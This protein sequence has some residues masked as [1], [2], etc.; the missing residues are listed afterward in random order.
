LVEVDATYYALL[1]PELAERWVSTTPADFCFDVKAHPIVTGHPVDIAR[2]PADLKRALE[3]AGHSR[4]VYPDRMPPEIAGEIEQRFRALV[5]P[6]RAAGKLGCVMVQFPPWFKATR[7]N[8]Q[9]IERLGERW[10]GVPI[11]IEFRD[12]SWLLPERRERVLDLLRAHSFSY[13][14]VDEP[15]VATGGVPPLV[16]VTNPE[17]SLVRFHGHNKAGW[18]KKGAGVHERFDYLYTPEELAAWADPVRELSRESKR[19]HALFNN[20]VRNYAVLGAKGLSVIL[21]DGS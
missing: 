12:R 17:L 21:K 5:E 3:D 20:C 7:G 4:R 19:V 9:R 8:A 11:S 13:V 2:L 16:A 10:A 18:L 14:V 1:P 6:L 15:D